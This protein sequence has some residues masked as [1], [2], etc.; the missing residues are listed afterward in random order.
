MNSRKPSHEVRLRLHCS[1]CED[2]RSHRSQ[3]PSAQPTKGTC[4]RRTESAGVSRRNE[5]SLR[6]RGF[7]R[8]TTRWRRELN[9]TDR[10]FDY[11][12]ACVGSPGRGRLRNHAHERSDGKNKIPISYSPVVGL[13]VSA[14]LVTWRT[15]SRND[16]L[17]RL[18]FMS[19]GKYPRIFLNPSAICLATSI[20]INASA[21]STA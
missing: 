3:E 16:S 20:L 5:T 18:I 19:C 12:W 8:E 7:P 1:R 4:S 11:R 14:G 15:A 10:Q 6:I 21:P 9:S 17:S 13:L 2:R